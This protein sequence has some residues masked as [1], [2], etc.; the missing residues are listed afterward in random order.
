M[1]VTREEFKAELKKNGFPYGYIPNVYEKFK[2]ENLTVF[3]ILIEG[4]PFVVVT[5]DEKS[6]PEVSE[7]SGKKIEPYSFEWLEN[8]IYDSNIIG[9]SFYESLLRHLQM[10]I[11]VKKAEKNDETKKQKNCPYCD[12]QLLAYEIGADPIPES[13]KGY[14]I[15]HGDIKAFIA[16]ENGKYYLMH[17]F[18]PDDGYFLKM[19]IHN[20]PICGRKLE[21]KI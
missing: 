13:G 19:E 5:D 11:R 9:P 20:C 3:R 4:C 18:T 21:E 6:F 2:Q 10:Y 16:K 8:L 7:E 12:E 1:N 14:A 15:E 17:N